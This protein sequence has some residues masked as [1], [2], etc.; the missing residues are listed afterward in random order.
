MT[1]GDNSGDVL[2]APAGHKLRSLIERLERLANDKACVS[3]DMKE[4]FAE[5]KAEGFDN[6]ILRKVLK[7]RKTDAAKRQEE[8]ALVELYVSAIGGL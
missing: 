1:I 7:L 2:S 6:R 5:S 3:E 8:D 4:V